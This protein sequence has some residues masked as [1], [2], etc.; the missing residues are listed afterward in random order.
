[1]QTMSF[2]IPGIPVVILGLTGIMDGNQWYRSDPDFCTVGKNQSLQ[3]KRKVGV[4]L[5]L[6][7][8]KGVFF[9]LCVFLNAHKCL[10]HIGLAKFC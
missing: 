5:R 3:I 1:M 8:Q 10:S 4:S 6:V 7:N 9:D 2:V